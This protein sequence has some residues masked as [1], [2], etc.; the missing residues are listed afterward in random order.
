MHA[1]LA[2]T[3]VGQAERNSLVGMGD[4]NFFLKQNFQHQRYFLRARNPDLKFNFCLS[5]ILLAKP[6]SAASF[7][8]FSWLRS[9]PCPSPTHCPSSLGTG[10]VTFLPSFRDKV[11]TLLTLMKNEMLTARWMTT[12]VHKYQ[13]EL[14]CPASPWIKWTLY[15]RG[16][17]AWLKSVGRSGGGHW[18][19]RT[20]I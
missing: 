7:S 4:L 19:F 11:K 13:G 1:S 20:L 3:R 5:L 14:Y 15:S 2:K 10:K 16:C 9:C 18:R 12:A 6:K 17:S 8:S